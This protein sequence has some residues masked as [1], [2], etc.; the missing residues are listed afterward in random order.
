MLLKSVIH[1]KVNLTEHEKRGGGKFGFRVAEVNLSE[2][3]GT[4]EPERPLRSKLGVCFQLFIKEFRFLVAVLKG[5]CYICVVVG[6]EN[7][8]RHKQGLEDEKKYYPV[9]SH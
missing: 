5:C 3:T 9:S 1:A 4:F 8:T 2:I 7:H 6:G